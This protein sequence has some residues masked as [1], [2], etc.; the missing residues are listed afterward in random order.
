MSN[1]EYAQ[2]NYKKKQL[3]KKPWAKKVLHKAYISKP[4]GGNKRLIKQPTSCI[5]EILK[6][7]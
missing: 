6:V 5:D 3:T 4:H 2:R 7:P 1:T